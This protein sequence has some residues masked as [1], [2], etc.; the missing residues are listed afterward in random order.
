MFNHVGLPGEVVEMSTTNVKGK[1][2][3]ITPDGAI[4][5]SVTTVLGSGEDA[6][7]L[8]NWRNMLGEQKAAKETQRC[9]DRGTAVHK[10]ME[11][12]INNVDPDE[13]VRGHTPENIKLFNQ[14]KLVIRNKLTDVQAQ[15][16]AL[17]SDTLRMAGRVDCIGTYEGKPCI[18][19][20]KTAT[21]TNYAHKL[22][23][24]FQQMTAYAIMYSEMYNVCVEDIVVLMCTER[25]LMPMV[26][27][28]RIDNHVGPLLTTI[29][30]YWKQAS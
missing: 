1:R 12:Y 9:A 18:L 2:H 28:D 27:R 8:Q 16:V 21:T 24:Y 20:F 19:D 6:A 30:K 11:D 22:P 7:A 13:L 14:L 5:P 15:E 4:Y 26:F 23:K 3:Y 29:K 25:G 10:M 17:Y